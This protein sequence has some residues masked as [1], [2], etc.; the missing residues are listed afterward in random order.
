MARAS[1]FKRALQDTQT[2]RTL[3]VET[4]GDRLDPLQFIEWAACNPPMRHA[5]AFDPQVRLAE[6]DLPDVTGVKYHIV[7]EGY[8]DPE[9]HPI[10]DAV[11]AM[12]EREVATDRVVVE[13]SGR[14]VAEWRQREGIRDPVPCVCYIGASIV[15]SRA[16]D[17]VIVGST[18]RNRELVILR[19]RIRRSSLVRVRDAAEFVRVHEGDGASA[20]RNRYLSA[21][22][23]SA[24]LRETERV[25]H[26]RTVAEAAEFSG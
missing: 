22:C 11:E 1:S 26:A 6:P 8:R 5:G 13:G 25:E 19:I 3:V 12:M 16:I 15:E 9:I 17:S 24:I 20:G 14:P 7:G 23:M 18:K 10:I 4:Y 21:F 2:P